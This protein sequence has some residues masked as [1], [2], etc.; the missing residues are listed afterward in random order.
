MARLQVFLL[1][2]LLQELVFAQV[3]RLCRL[4]SS[5]H[6]IFSTAPHRPVQKLSNH[7]FSN[8]TKFF[9]SQYQSSFFF[10]VPLTF[11]NPS[12]VSSI[13]LFLPSS[14]PLSLSPFNPPL[15]SSIPLFLP[16]SN[17][18]CMPL[19]SR[20]REPVSPLHFAANVS[21]SKHT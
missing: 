21:M 12:L 16:H 14:I 4:L 18:Y 11:F 6:H 7:L 15:P 19:P 10:F 1:H 20:C 3:R 2:L 13:P 17:I 8:C 9:N 5:V